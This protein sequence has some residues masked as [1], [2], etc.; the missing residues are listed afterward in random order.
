M[1]G[2]SAHRL[3]ESLDLQFRADILSVEIQPNERPTL[4]RVSLGVCGGVRLARS[5]SD[6]DFPSAGVCGYAPRCPRI[7][8]T[9]CEPLSRGGF[10]YLLNGGKVKGYGHASGRLSPEPRDHQIPFSKGSTGS[11]GTSFPCALPF[12]I[13]IL[14]QNVRDV[15]GLYA[16]PFGKVPCIGLT[17]PAE[18]SRVG[19]VARGG[20][21]SSPCFHG[22]RRQR[23]RRPLGS[24]F[25]LLGGMEFR[26]IVCPR[27]HVHGLHPLLQAGALTTGKQVPNEVL[28]AYTK[29]VRINNF[30]CISFTWASL[31]CG[32]TGTSWQVI[33][34]ERDGSEPCR[35]TPSRWAML[36]TGL[37]VV[38]RRRS[39]ESTASWHAF[40]GKYFT[41]R[42][43]SRHLH[44]FIT[45]LWLHFPSSPHFY[46][47]TSFCHGRKFSRIGYWVERD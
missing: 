2:S 18:R 25:T 1:D 39:L 37:T 30:R 12:H 33:L 44:S 16:L 46:E 21:Y 32:V 42:A 38:N 43:Q 8:Q 15:C 40:N 47:T 31:G 45:H 3:I 34:E 6:N 28:A 7:F 10:R 13:Q 9:V 41:R 27:V 17:C 29:Q 26:E 22:R 19:F 23:V 5:P 4:I 35:L 20:V 24:T 14:A 36:D 11:G